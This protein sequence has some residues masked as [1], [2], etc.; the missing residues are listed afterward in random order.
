MK[1]SISENTCNKVVFKGKWG[2]ECLL[3]CEKRNLAWIF[4][5]MFSEQSYNRVLY[6]TRDILQKVSENVLVEMKL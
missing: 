1:K 4:F 2:S 3:F 6:I 5:R